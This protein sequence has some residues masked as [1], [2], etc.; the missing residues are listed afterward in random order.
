M[1]DTSA[2]DCA[3]V[4]HLPLTGEGPAPLSASE[5]VSTPISKN[6]TVPLYPVHVPDATTWW[7]SL[8]AYMHTGSDA[9]E[10]CEEMLHRPPGHVAADIETHGLAQGRWTITCVTLAFRDSAGDIHSVLLDPLRNAQDAQMLT[11]VLDHASM[12]I[13][14]N[15]EF[16]APVLWVH[17]FLDEAG[18]R[19]IH[20]TIIL[21]RM[22]RTHMTGGRTLEEL[23]EHYEVST[24]SSVKM[25]NVFAAAGYRT[26]DEG[27]QQCDIDVPSYRYGAM[28][29]TIVTL[30]IAPPLYADVH[31]R[32]VRGAAG[33]TAA[34][35]LSEAEAH[36]L[37]ADM[38]QV[39]QVTLLASCRGLA[40]DIE[41]AS[42]W[43]AKHWPGVEAA[44][45]FITSETRG[46]VD[47]GNG[48]HLVTYLDEIG[49]LPDDWARTDK[50]ALKSDK[51]AMERLQTLG[52][53]LAQQHTLIAEFRKNWNYMQTLEESAAVTGRVHPSMK[54]L[55]AAA[56]GRMAATSPALQQFSE[57]AR[58]VI[59]ADPGET[60]WSVDWSSIEPVVMANCAGD[61]AFID[62][63]NQGH[64]LY[65]PV[66]RA[67]GLIP[68]DISEEDAASHPGRKKAK[69]VLLAAM[70]G[71]GVRSLAA[72]LNITVDEAYA[73]RD[74][75]RH[76]MQRSF[77]F[78]DN[79]TSV[80]DR[81]G[82]IH[83]I[84]GRVLDERDYS[85][86][87]EARKAVNHFCQGSAADVLLATTL[88]LD[89]MGASHG[90]RLWIH[91][92][93]VVTAEVLDAVKEAMSTPPEWL[94]HYSGL[95]G[96][97]PILR[98]DAQEL[99]KHWQ[100]V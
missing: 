65:I 100:K 49:A 53:D 58:P 99:G 73:L 92:E 48:A 68:H 79:I 74:A 93:L 31:S 18:V 90:I 7:M 10:A 13:L 70:Y 84:S 26:K 71:Q 14:H 66:A 62:P 60:W 96:M 98:I 11:R 19:K 25:A 80:A 88:T 75:L 35:L 12:L 1:T 32:L 52:H 39:N 36:Q 33:S 63:F 50:G 59:C 8:G 24:D 21:A 38:H 77:A 2:P 94:S 40:I 81:T 97:V 83:T 3:D 44:E 20:D 85:G 43:Y 64:D 5:L 55:G 61:R 91:D 67:A 87:I 23:A 17:G 9:R 4:L 47:P 82:Q 56:S 78:M 22:T 86:K 29:D 15:A 89:R 45:E 34:A 27:Y 30:R 16:D 57:D 69:V 76:A 46:E 51:K 54:V 37:I 41:K 6:L 72:N 42:Q 28:S 95:A